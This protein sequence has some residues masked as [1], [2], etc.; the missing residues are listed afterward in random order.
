MHLWWFGASMAGRFPALA[1]VVCPPAA[2]G[3]TCLQALKAAA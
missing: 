2:Y 1:G 3:T